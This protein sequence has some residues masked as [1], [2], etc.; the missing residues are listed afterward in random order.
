[1]S[2]DNFILLYRNAL[3]EKLPKGYVLLLI[4]I[5]SKAD[6][7]R[8]TDKLNRCWEER[9]IVTDVKNGDR[10]MLTIAGDM[11][12]EAITE[13]VTKA[14]HHDYNLRSMAEGEGPMAAM[15]RAMQQTGVT[16]YR[17]GLP[18]SSTPVSRPSTVKDAVTSNRLS[19]SDPKRYG[20][21]PIY[22]ILCPKCTAVLPPPD[23]AGEQVCPLCGEHTSLRRQAS[24]SH[25]PGANVPIKE[26]IPLGGFRSGE[27]GIRLPTRKGSKSPQAIPAWVI[28]MLISIFVLPV[29]ILVLASLMR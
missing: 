14:S 9:A 8:F 10:I 22:A 12:T 11:T 17:I 24:T 27:H 4:D 16:G 19:S 29:V 15:T 3:Y 23:P 28:L 25:K 26:S 2:I 6:S 13:I 7:D 18:S 1:M 5:P 20:D 21:G